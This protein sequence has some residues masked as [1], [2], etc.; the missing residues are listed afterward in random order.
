MS[1]P[2]S[3][4]SKN[5]GLEMRKGISLAFKEQNQN[6][7]VHG[8][9][10]ELEFR[11]DGYDP[12]EAEAAVRDLLDVQSEPGVSPR[13]PTTSMPL[14]TGQTAVSTDALERGPNTVLALL[15][16]VGTPTMVR[17]A[18]IAVETGTLFFGAFTGATLMLRN[19]AAGACAKYIFNVRASY[20]EEA[21]ATTEFFL[22]LGVPDDKH[23]MS[24]DQND[25]FGQAGY[26]G[27]LAAYKAL[28]GDPKDVVNDMEPIERLRYVRDDET[29]VPEQVDRA[30]DYLAE[31]LSD[32]K[33]HTVG[34]FMTDT[35]GPATAFITA[36]RDWQ[37]QEGN[38]AASRL[39]LLFSNVSF[40]GPNALSERLLMAGSAQTS[41]GSKPYSEG[42]YVSQVVPNYQN[43]SGDLV[44]SYRAA[45]ESDGTGLTES[46]TSL[47]GY[48]TARVFVAGLVAHRGR[49]TPDALIG[50]FEHLPELALGIGASAGFSAESHQ[51]SK[52]VWG[53]SIDPEGSFTD[54]YYWTEGTAL[55]LVE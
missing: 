14:V 19:A 15:G 44:R 45:L 11:D 48:L 47:E 27:L 38:L 39:K 42:V 5:L 7:G 36:V 1:A 50:T 4:T 33:N 22:K 23:L 8:R 6:G 20:A 43:D 25:S 53:T 24:F 34:I 46:F 16:N 29:S 21:R 40:V 35:Y 49:Y 32:G 26:D 18:P 28:R 9:Q 2:I 10:L 52:S 12:T 55:Q 37:Y 13:C 51:Y 30:I 3:G 41:S 54:R 31:L 17:T